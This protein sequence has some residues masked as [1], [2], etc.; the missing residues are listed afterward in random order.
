MTAI[1]K[2]L[3]GT[4]APSP[5]TIGEVAGR[6][7]LNASRIRYYEEIGVLPRPE[8]VAGQRRY[9]ADVLR[10]LMIIGVAQ[11]V[12]LTLTEI[13][14]LTGPGIAGGESAGE[15]ASSRRASCPRSRR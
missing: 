4:G 8:R 10:R 3:E 15:S 9:G 12:G 2:P 7:G 11:R 5:M 6:A 13:G 14:D 1:A